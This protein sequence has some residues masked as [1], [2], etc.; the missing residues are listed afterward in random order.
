MLIAHTS[1]LWY[2]SYSTP[3]ETEVVQQHE[4]D[5]GFPGPP[6]G[7]SGPQATDTPSPASLHPINDLPATTGAQLYSSTKVLWEKAGLRR[8]P[9]L[10]TPCYILDEIQGL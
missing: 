1:Q 9:Q 10:C 7:I 4:P 8:S 3:G 2:P 6:K 5:A